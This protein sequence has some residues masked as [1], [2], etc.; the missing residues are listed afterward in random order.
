MVNF[1][2]S[3]RIFRAYSLQPKQ[4]K[5]THNCY[6]GCLNK[7]CLNPL[8][9]FL[10]KSTLPNIAT[11]S[12]KKMGSRPGNPQKSFQVCKPGPGAS[13]N[14]TIGALFLQQ[15]HRAHRGHS[16]SLRV[17]VDRAPSANLEKDLCIFF[18]GG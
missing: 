11:S 17:E 12:L 13:C 1:T 3:P 7:L 16:G 5:K 4:P 10:Y 2:G 6:K 9:V 14:R 15:H 8:T 18:L